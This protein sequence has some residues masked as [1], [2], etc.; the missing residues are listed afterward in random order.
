MLPLRISDWTLCSALGDGRQSTLDALRKRRGG[1]TPND[2]GAEPLRTWV[3]RVPGLQA[4]PL[5]EK[6]AQYDCRNNRLAWR[7]L[8][9]DGFLATVERAQ[10]RYGANRVAVI[11]GTS[12][13][14]IGASEEAY[15][16]LEN[17]S[18]PPDLRRPLV[19]TL[20]SLGLFVARALNLKGICTTVETACSSSAK[21]FAQAERVM[22]A[23]LADAVV[24]GGVDSLCGSV[25]YGFN[26][27]EL[28]SSE[29][30][31]PFDVQRAGISIG[32]AAG[33]ALLE[34]TAGSGPLMIGYGESSDAYHMSAP[35]PEG[36]GAQLA[37]D[38]T[39]QRAQ[40]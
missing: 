11:V 14:S 28:V 31:R 8:N 16:R 25:L 2:F 23:G 34:R 36:G 27:L 39:L 9:T 6:F 30:C 38:V 20:H 15:T 4:A 3:G 1:L 35:H 26:S 22:R 32:E 33:F 12:T 40:L 13:S 29:P 7:A 18:Y 19:H 21:V 10:S 17:G 24:V 5:P 37:I